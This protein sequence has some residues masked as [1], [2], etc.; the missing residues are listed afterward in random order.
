MCFHSCWFC[1]GQKRRTGLKS[2]CREKLERRKKMRWKT[3]RSV[4][5]LCSGKCTWWNIEKDVQQ[6]VQCVLHS[7]LQCAKYYWVLPIVCVCDQVPLIRFCTK[8]PMS[9]FIVKYQQCSALVRVFIVKCVK[10]LSV[11]VWKCADRAPHSVLT[12]SSVTTICPCH[13]PA[14][15]VLP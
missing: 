9:T 3:F 1:A 5:S 14:A 13:P 10:C 8:I 2:I 15:S 11:L 12:L 6:L 4:L 7:T